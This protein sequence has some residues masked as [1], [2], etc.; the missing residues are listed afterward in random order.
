MPEPAGFAAIAVDAPVQAC[1][2]D[3][4]GGLDPDAAAALLEPAIRVPGDAAGVVE[5]VIEDAGAKRRVLERARADRPLRL[6]VHGRH[7][8]RRRDHQADLFAPRRILR[9]LE[10]DGPSRPRRLRLFDCPRQ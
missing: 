5:A 7:E 9:D 4:A 3:F 6:D 1:Q 2:A 8:G 10:G